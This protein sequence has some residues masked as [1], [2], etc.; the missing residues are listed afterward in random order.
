VNTGGVPSF[1][2][3]IVLDAVEVLPHASV[4][5]QIRVL[6]LTHPTVVTGS[7]PTV[8]GV[9]LPQLSVAVAFP[10]LVFCCEPFK[11]WQ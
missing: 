2:H 8:V 11:F 4:A 1:D 7:N 10:R 9:T 5:S 6:E 3:V